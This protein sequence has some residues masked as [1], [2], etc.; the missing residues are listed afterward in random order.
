MSKW[1]AASAAFI[2]AIS[3][4]IYFDSKPAAMKTDAAPTVA[5]DNLPMIFS[6][7]GWLPSL[8]QPSTLQMKPVIIKATSTKLPPKFFDFE[9]AFCRE[10]EGVRGKVRRCAYTPDSI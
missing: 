5:S 4:P 8:P 2:I 1:I 10:V 3:L 7:V 9:H 6:D